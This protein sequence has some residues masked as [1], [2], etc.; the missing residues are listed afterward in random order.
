M[1]WLSPAVV[2]TSQMD[3]G[4]AALTSVL[5]GFGRP[6]QLE[7]LHDVCR[8]GVDGTSINVMTVLARALGLAARQVMVPIDHLRSVRLGLLPAV[9]VIELPDGMLHFIVLWRRIGNLIQVMD[10]AVGRRWI[11]WAQLRQMLF[12]HSQEVPAEAWRNYA[13]GPAFCDPLRERLEHLGASSEATE[14]LVGGAILDPGW[15]P[16]ARLD[17]SARVASNLQ[18]LESGN[19]PPDEAW[20]VRP[21]QDEARL[22]MSGVVI[23]TVNGLEDD[24]L[25]ETLACVCLLGGISVPAG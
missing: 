10:P 22:V 25:D 6:A 4:P 20:M 5:R 8:T 3:C 11:R 16:I 2:Q 15:E 14:E 9:A 21:A 17:A 23:L 24:G 12:L 13:G 19:D 7:A 1:R 18:D